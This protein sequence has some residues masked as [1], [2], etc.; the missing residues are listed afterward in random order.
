M[1]QRLFELLELDCHNLDLQLALTSAQVSSSSSSYQRYIA[2]KRKVV[3]TQE[4]LEERE[5]QLKGME[6][7]GSYLAL[8]MSTATTDPRLALIREKAEELKVKIASLVS[9]TFV[10]MHSGLCACLYRGE[11]DRSMKRRQ[12][13]ASQSQ[14]A[15]LCNPWILPYSPSMFRGRHTTAAPLWAI[16]SIEH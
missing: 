13:E 7:Q 15:R 9:T 4:Q 10:N 12:R 14:K 3:A 6:Q 8:I 11:R 1:F 5:N 16:T 2:A